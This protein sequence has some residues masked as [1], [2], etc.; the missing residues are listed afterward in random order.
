MVIGNFEWM[1]C[2]TLILLAL[3]FAPFYIRTGITTLPEFLEKRY[4]PPA[5]TFLA[6]IGI[7]GA[8]LIHIGISMFTA[9]KLFESFLGV[10]M[11]VSILVISLFTVTYTA[12]GGL[13]AVVVTE[14]IQVF[15]L[16]GSAIMVTVLAV[17]YLPAARHPRRGGVQGGDEARPVEH[18]APHPQS[19]HGTLEPLFLAGGPPGL[20]DS[21]HLVLV[22]RPDARAARAGREERAERPKRRPVRRLPQAPARVPD[23]FSRHRRLDHVSER[24]L[25]TWRAIRRSPTTT[26]CWHR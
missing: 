17:L 9:A 8:L 16:L 5:R 15:L 25:S 21:R 20:S 24:L 7:L 22:L 2:L 13:K 12:L 1:A 18:A 3:V 19:R 26:C 11:Y 23:G 10:N 6:I 14:T 4:G